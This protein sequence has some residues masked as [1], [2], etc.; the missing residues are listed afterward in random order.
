MQ[1]YYSSALTWFLSCSQP[2]PKMQG[3]LAVEYHLKYVDNQPKTVQ[4]NSSSVLSLDF[5]YPVFC[6]KTF[7]FLGKITKRMN[8]TS[9]ETF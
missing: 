7:L 4:R 2:L 5:S 1:F 3:L 9:E 6:T 8:L